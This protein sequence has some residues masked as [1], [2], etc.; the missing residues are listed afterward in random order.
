MSCVE[1]EAICAC[2]RLLLS[3]SSQTHIYAEAGFSQNTAVLVQFEPLWLDSSAQHSTTRSLSESK[4][5]KALSRLTEIAHLARVDVLQRQV[6][7][8]P[9]GLS[10][11][12]ARVQLSRPCGE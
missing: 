3:V 8:R 7:A 12:T 4:I 2:F 10:S 11:A 6:S 1:T 5:A 9:I